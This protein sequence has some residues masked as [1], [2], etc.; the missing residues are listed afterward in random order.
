MLPLLTTLQQLLMSN[1]GK[2]RKRNDHKEDLN[3]VK[4]CRRG[5]CYTP[6]KKQKTNH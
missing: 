6:E 4:S 5:T 2:K 3:V 1:K